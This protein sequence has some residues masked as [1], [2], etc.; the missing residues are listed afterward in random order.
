MGR[1]SDHL[2][3]VPAHFR[4]RTSILPTHPLPA[5]AQTLFPVLAPPELP[6]P[7]PK[8]SPSHAPLSPARTLLP[9]HPPTPAHA[10]PIPALPRRSPGSP[11]RTCSGRFSR[12]AASNARAPP[13]VTVFLETASLASAVGYHIMV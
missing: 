12:V 5:L 11:V 3:L 13:L 9:A 6:P 1:R 8:L 4:C 2:G 7:A 10:V